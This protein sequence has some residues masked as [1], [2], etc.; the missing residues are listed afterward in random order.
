MEGRKGK[1][2]GSKGGMWGRGRERGRTEERKE[3]EK[4]TIFIRDSL[5]GEFPFSCPL[6]VMH[7]FLGGFC[8]LHVEHR[9]KVQLV[10]RSNMR[11]KGKKSK[12]RSLLTHNHA[13]LS[14]NVDLILIQSFYHSSCFFAFCLEFTYRIQ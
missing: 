13:E 3:K 11:D 14:E 6:A 7:S 12:Y 9:S 2:K 1:K 4:L 10:L 8:A 5:T